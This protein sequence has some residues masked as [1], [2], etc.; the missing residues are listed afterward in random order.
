[1]ATAQLPAIHDS[2]DKIF[3]AGHAVVVLDGASAFL[4]VPV[5]ASVYAD[6]LG[7]YLRDALNAAPD[8]DLRRL[9]ADG[10]EH[11]AR[12]LDLTPGRSPS[13]TVAIARELDK[14]VEFLLLG[15]SVIVLPEEVLTDARMDDLD[16]EP[17]RRYRERLAAG[18]GYDSEHTA[19]LRELQEQQAARRNQPGGYW[20]AEADPVAAEHALVASHPVS[21]APWAVLLTDGAYTTMDHL[22]LDDWPHL[23][24]SD[25][26][27]L[28]DMLH[29]CEAW[30]AHGDPDAGELP[31]AKRHDDKSLAAVR[32]TA[33]PACIAGS[34]D[35]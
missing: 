31:R 12:Q 13:S 5:P 27:K 19:L 1:M 25:T 33:L 16:L 30:E 24:H 3:T 2:D 4:P 11:T 18:H 9:L 6:H 20:I 23:V 14:R 32:F 21:T 26:G 34:S 17:R 10:I 15:D 22:G 29:H 28:A 8:A 35:Q 7:S